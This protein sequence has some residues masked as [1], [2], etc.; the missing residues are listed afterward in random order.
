MHVCV[1]VERVSV[2]IATS[3]TQAKVSGSKIEK[4]IGIGV[5]SYTYTKATS[6]VNVCVCV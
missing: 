6:R 5:F 1:C 4:L 3:R 2:C